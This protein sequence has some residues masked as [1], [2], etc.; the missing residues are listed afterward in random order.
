MIKR[1]FDLWSS[2]APAER[3]AA[4]ILAI[5]VGVLLCFWFLH[6]AGQ[7]RNRLKILV[8]TLKSQSA[9]MDQQRTEYG[10]LKAASANK[11][12]LAPQNL[13]EVIQ[14]LIDSAGLSTSLIKM[15]ASDTGAVQISLNALSFANW[16]AFAR[17]LQT[18]QIGIEACR[19][20]AQS[21]DQVR[22]NATLSSKH[23]R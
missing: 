2:R 9:A 8:S 6:I 23:V 20:E 11:P 10:Q 7:E 4:A 22:I 1:M 16:L 12:P 13:R 5:V 3:T 14:G 15:D 21:A 19:I 17:N 18:Q